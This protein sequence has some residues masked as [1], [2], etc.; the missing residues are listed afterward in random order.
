MLDIGRDAMTTALPERVPIVSA[1]LRPPHRR[2]Q[3]DVGLRSVPVAQRTTSAARSEPAEPASLGRR[4]GAVL[5]DWILCV[6]VASIFAD[7]RRTPWPAPVVLIGE[8]AFF[9]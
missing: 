6:M 9:I 8:Y 4:F 1:M 7:P 3:V 2:P 5:V